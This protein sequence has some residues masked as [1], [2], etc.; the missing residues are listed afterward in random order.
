MQQN[1]PILPPEDFEYSETHELISKKILQPYA[2]TAARQPYNSVQKRVFYRIIELMQVTMGGLR[3]DQLPDNWRISKDLWG[4][5]QFTIPVQHCYPKNE[6]PNYSYIKKNFLDMAKKRVTFDEPV[7]GKLPITRSFALFTRAAYDPNRKVFE[8]TIQ[9]D[10]LTAFALILK[11]HTKIDLAVAF[12]LKSVWS[13]R[14][15]EFVCSIDHPVTYTLDELRN[16]FALGSGYKRNVEIFRNIID[17]AQKELRLKSPDHFTYS[18]RKKPGSK[19]IEAITIFPKQNIKIDPNPAKELKRLSQELSPRNYFDKE[20][21]D[22]CYDV[23]GFE[24]KGLKN[25]IGTFRKAKKSLDIDKNWLMKTRTKALN[26]GCT[27]DRLPGY[28]IN[29]MKLQMKEQNLTDE[30]KALKNLQQSLN[31]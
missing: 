27:Q 25:N 13:M 14:F 15:Y 16:M 1:F 18:K 20:F 5:A 4:E 11:R 3:I 28:I 6:Y 7:K 29:T 9:K 12:Q 17:V 23:I 19:T 8:F 10:C 2:F 22:Y 26:N 30:Q 21:L 24:P 31:F